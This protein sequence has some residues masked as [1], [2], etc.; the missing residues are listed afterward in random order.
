[1]AAEAAVVQS[2]LVHT[3]VFWMAVAIFCVT[4]A[5]VVIEVVHRV[6]AVLLG[7]VSMILAGVM[8][9]ETAIRAIDF[10]TLGLLIGM[11]VIINILKTTGFFQYIAIKTM[12]LS[13]GK[14]VWVAV[15]FF[16]ATAACSALLDNVTTVLFIAPITI[17]I[18]ST[19]DM[20]P[21]PF[22][23]V[24]IIASNI[25][26][27]ATLI[28]DPPNIMIGSQT[29]LTF[30]DFLMHLTPV[31]IL[32]SAVVI[33]MVWFVFHGRLKADPDKVAKAL[34]IDERQY[35]KDVPVLR[36]SLVVITVTMIGFMLHG[37]LHLEAAT[38]ALTGASVL[39][40]L[41]GHDPHRHLPEIEWSTIFFFAGLFVVVGGV[42]HVGV[43]EIAAD[44]LVKVTSGNMLVLSMSVLVFSAVVSAVVDNIP[45]VAA[46][47][48]VLLTIAK[49]LY[50]DIHD[51]YQ[52]SIHPGIMPLWWSLALGACLGGNGTLV[53]ASANVVV[54]GLAAKAGH[55]ISFI[56]YLK[57][58]VPVTVVSVILSG[59][60]VWLRYF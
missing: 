19:L 21:I 40:L 43:L 12:K 59:L 2:G 14:P 35:L 11:M 30:V 5:L 46:L 29:G 55:P 3:S 26:G 53:G 9:Q 44:W 50:P 60:Y 34:A 48:P 58:G 6:V 28:G 47:I 56:E 42:E 18:A 49:D 25:G 10:N 24:E 20:N 16:V 39:L 54:S 32:I 1:M 45:A 4:Y 23:Y 52:L 57:V 22:L 51:L 8:S 15:G 41:V 36:K 27:T 7:A 13:G 33:G 17:V 37:W 31:I 38:I